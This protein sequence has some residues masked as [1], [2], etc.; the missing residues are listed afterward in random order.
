MN[1]QGFNVYIDDIEEYT[2]KGKFVRNIVLFGIDK[3]SDILL[4][5][6]VE[7]FYDD[8]DTSEYIRDIQRSLRAPTSIRASGKYHVKVYN[9]DYGDLTFSVFDE[10]MTIKQVK[11]LLKEIGREI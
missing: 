7:M 1:K 3:G 2:E 5:G 4:E 8:E 11:E 9:K 6:F 10:G